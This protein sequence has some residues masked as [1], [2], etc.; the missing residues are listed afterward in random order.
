MKY[1]KK[2]EFFDLEDWDEVNDDDIIVST[3]KIGDKFL[4]INSNNNDVFTV[5]KVDE[6]GVY[7]ENGWYRLLKNCKKI[8]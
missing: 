7:D 4:D 6:D 5:S 8:K 3:L 2:Y 1:L